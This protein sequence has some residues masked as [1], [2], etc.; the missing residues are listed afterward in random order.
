M[1]SKALDTVSEVKSRLPMPASAVSRGITPAQWRVLVETTFPSAKSAE[2]VEMAFDYCKV[3]GLDVF[4]K[5]VHIVPMWNS[6]LRREVETVWAGINE[7]QI[8]AARSGAWA[9]MDSPK[10]GPMITKTFEGER[11]SNNGTQH[12]SVEV[13][14]PEWCEVTVYRMVQGQRC[15]FAEPV[16]WEEACSTMGK[17][18]KLPT[19]MWV[20][21]PRG[22]LQKV[23]KSASLRAAFPE[24]AELTAEEMEGKEIEAGGAI[25]DHEPARPS[26]D[27]NALESEIRQSLIDVNDID[28]LDEVWLSFRDRVKQ[29]AA[30]NDGNLNRFTQHFSARKAMILVDRERQVEQ[31]KHDD[32]EN[33]TD[34]TVADLP[35]PENPAIPEPGDD[36][37]KFQLTVDPKTNQPRWGALTKSLKGGL[38]QAIREN[39]D[40]SEVVGFWNNHKHLVERMR[41]A[42]GD[43]VSY[44]DKLEEL[45]QETIAKLEAVE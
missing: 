34:A 18:S 4:K 25:I 20:K 26:I 21:R 32:E 27:A 9:G 14:Y 3:R 5:P 23:A 35:A 33:P 8:T 10:W 31:A 41:K 30:E 16:Y 12:V 19:D 38:E 29:A 28:H 17:N 7:I 37:P 45:Y 22:Q 15:A 2:A 1:A 13:T 43:Y 36:L 24:E 6:S 39:R 11:R 40:A 44:A 42:G